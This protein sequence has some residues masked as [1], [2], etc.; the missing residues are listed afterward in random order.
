[1]TDQERN[2]AEA[3]TA[4][5]REVC[6]FVAKGWSGPEIAEELEISPRT[7]EA[8]IY[9][10]ARLIPGRG[11]PMKRI[12]RFFVGRLEDLSPK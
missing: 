6:L 9:S 8:H 10:A 7:V 12:M 1:M 3:L 4:R 5:E 2:P 11:T